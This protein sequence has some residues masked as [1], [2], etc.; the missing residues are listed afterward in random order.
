MGRVD[1][2]YEAINKDKLLKAINL[3]QSADIDEET[4]DVQW[5]TWYKGF[6]KDVEEAFDLVIRYMQALENKG[7]ILDNIRAEIESI[8][9]YCTNNNHDIWLRTPE[10][11]KNEALHI[12]DKYKE[13]EK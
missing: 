7:N 1:N 12:I 10:E 3:L 4:G 5:H 8:E 9:R 6:G 13:R 11:I 2:T